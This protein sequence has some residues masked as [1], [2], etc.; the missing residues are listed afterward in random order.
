MKMKKFFYFFLLLILFSLFVSGSDFK[1]LF[2]LR[3]EVDLF[4]EEYNGNS[5][6]AELIRFDGDRNAYFATLDAIQKLSPD[7]QYIRPFVVRNKG[8]NP[9]GLCEFHSYVFDSDGNLIACNR[10][11]KSIVIFDKKGKEIRNIKL[12]K[13]P[14]QVF[15]N[16]RGDLFLELNNLPGE[17][18]FEKVDKNFNSQKCLFKE[19]GKSLLNGIVLRAFSADFDD[20]GNI[21]FIDGVDYKINVCDQ[22]GKYL[23]TYG[24][25]GT[26]FTAMT[27]NAP[28]PVNPN[29]INTKFD[30]WWD[31]W[32]VVS[33]MFIIKNKYLL[34]FFR[35]ER[36]IPQ[37]SP[38]FLDIYTL[39]GKKL[40][41][42]IVIPRGHIPIG[43][44]NNGNIYFTH[45]DYINF[46]QQERSNSK[47]V[48]AKLMKYSLVL[49]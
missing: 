22:D 26:R 38:S 21:Y 42:D 11:N 46:T 9:K 32:S 15:V 31:S 25:K 40:E 39:D 17:C 5:D 44:D 45:F 13:Y 30:K 8:L 2:K 19:S 20:D 47:M 18:R 33:D 49:Q 16:N 24:K 48:G 1:T 28:Y 3:K 10:L 23:M 35:C 41:T 12:D 14:N 4:K 43:R 29:A 27:G 6:T 7:L 34:I 37:I 36:K